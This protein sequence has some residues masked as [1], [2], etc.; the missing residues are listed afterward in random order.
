[1]K[2]RFV[3]SA[4]RSLAVAGTAVVLCG[5]APWP[6]P[7]ALH[8]K[9]MNA[10]CTDVHGKPVAGPR[11]EHGRLGGG[12]EFWALDE[13]GFQCDGAASLFSGSGGSQIL[14]YAAPSGR[15]PKQVFESGAYGMT[16]EPDGDRSRIWIKV[17]GEL[18]GQ[19]GE[20]VHATMMACDRSLE[21]DAKGEELTFASLSLARL[22]VEKAP[23]QSVGAEVGISYDSG[24]DLL[25]A[26]DQVLQSYWPDRV[27]LINW[28]ASVRSRGTIYN[29]A[30]TSAD[31]RDLLVS[32]FR[33][34]SCDPLCP[35][36][37]FTSAHRKIMDFEACGDRDRYRM[38]S[39]HRTLLACDKS[40]EI[41]QV[42][43]RDALMENAP[44]GSDRDAYVR[45]VLAER[46]RDPNAPQPISVMPA[47]HNNSQMLISEWKSGA[48]EIAYDIPRSG[49]PVARGT[50]LFKGV[51][52]GRVYRG[53]AYVFRSGCSPASFAVEGMKDPAKETLTFVGAVPRRATASCDILP[54]E[55]G[56]KR[57]RLVFD[58]RFY[59][60]E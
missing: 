57:T 21:W 18:C 52:T 46:S 58:T 37:V 47:N 55:S 36:R 51:R 2:T 24:S 48:V 59:G 12:Q 3:F 14:V 23:A 26:K 5:A 27:R 8:V 30:V 32:M 44:L 41:P 49:L 6:D 20:V 17:G 39:D 15:P 13:A 50:T 38:A 4:L 56:S 29:T 11:I 53:T 40:F 28:K 42:S 9:E 16:I 31:G 33:T 25:S 54:D 34:A 35:V 22:Q 43:A 10:F 45:V 1:M 7:V 19:T 60:D